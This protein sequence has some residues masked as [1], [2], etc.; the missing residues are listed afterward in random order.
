MS[1]YVYVHLCMHICKWIDIHDVCDMR[2]MCNIHIY[3]CVRAYIHK[4]MKNRTL[5]RLRA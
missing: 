4:K 3:M 5:E 2:V 1:L